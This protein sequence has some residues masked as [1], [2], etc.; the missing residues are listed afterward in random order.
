MSSRAALRKSVSLAATRP[1]AT[2]CVD[3]PGSAATATDAELRHKCL[4][5]AIR[6][7]EDGYAVVEGIIPE[8]VLSND[9]TSVMVV[10]CARCT[11]LSKRA[12]PIVLDS[13]V[14]RN[15]AGRTAMRMW[16]ACGTGWKA[17]APA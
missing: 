14:I 10:P 17:W 6:I 15:V 13:L 12:A 8:C 16:T 7:K 2:L 4:E 3:A 1:C 5:A 11:I 9:A